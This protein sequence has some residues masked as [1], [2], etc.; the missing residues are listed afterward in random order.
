[1]TPATCSRAAGCSGRR[2]LGLRLRW[3]WPR[4]WPRRRGRRASRAGPARAAAAALPRP[5]QAGHLPVHERRAVARRHV[6]P[7]A[8]ARPRRRQAVPVRQAARAV[9]P[10]RQPAASRRGSSSSTA[11]AGMPV[12][13]LFPHVARCVDDLC[14]IH[15]LHGTNPAHGGALLEAAHRQ[16]QLRPAE[17]GVV[18][19]LRPGDREPRTC[20]ASS[21]SA[22]R[23]RTAA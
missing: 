18:G 12:S 9:R 16:R 19:H 4:C 13:E 3:R 15:S 7:Q 21:P 11:R 14:V 10:D 22:R 2:A 20:P 23:W 6:R 8:A 17:H 5:G 1:M